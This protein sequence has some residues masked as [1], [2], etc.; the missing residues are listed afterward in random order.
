MTLRARKG[1]ERTVLVTALASE[2]AL[3]YRAWV[4]A[5]RKLVHE[6]TGERVGYLHIPDMGPWG[7]SEFHR[8]YLERVRS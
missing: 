2:A 6:R 5:N 8:G 3:R 1:E 4:E 7:F